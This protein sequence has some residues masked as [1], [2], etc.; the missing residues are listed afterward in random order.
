MPRFDQAADAALAVVLDTSDDDGEPA[1]AGTAFADV[2]SLLVTCH[3]VVDGRDH[4][5]L[6]N[7]SGDQVAVDRAALTMLPDYDLA[8]IRTTGLPVVP[9]PL[10]ADTGGAA[11]RFW[12]KGF[13]RT[14]SSMPGSFPVEGTLAGTAD[15]RYAS[16]LADYAIDGA[17]VLR[18]DTLGGGLSGAPVFDAD[19]G[20]VIGVLSTRLTEDGQA[21]GFA[22]PWPVAASAREIADVLAAN[23]RTVPAYGRHLNA[24]GARELCHAQVERAGRE[25]ADRRAVDVSRRVVR[26]TLDDAV[27]R[28]LAGDAM[29]LP[30][31]GPSGV[32]KSTELVARALTADR[33]ALLLRGS[34]I[35]AAHEHLGDA[36]C[37]ALRQS[38]GDRALPDRP[39]LAVAA[40]LASAGQRLLIFFDALNETPFSGAAL[41]EWITRSRAWLRETSSRMIMT[42][43]P[44]LWS[45]VHHVVTGNLVSETERIAPRSVGVEEFTEDEVRLAMRSYGLATTRVDERLLRLPL[46]LRLY[47]EL[48]QQPGIG[49]AATFHVHDLLAAYVSDRCRVVA[50]RSS[51]PGRARRIRDGLQRAAEE[52]WSAGTDHL[53]YGRFDELIGADESD[54]L[55]EEHLLAPAADES[56]YRFVYDDVQDWLACLHLDPD[57]ELSPERLALLDEPEGWRRVG[58][59]VHLLRDTERRAGHA[60]LR[61]HL[62]AIVPTGDVDKESHVPSLDVPGVRLAREVLTTV[63]DAVPYLGVLRAIAERSIAVRGHFRTDFWRLLA[64]PLPDRLDLL[65][66]LAPASHYHPWRVKDWR[67]SADADLDTWPA[68]HDYAA[69]TYQEAKQ[70]PLV[71]M[72]ALRSWFT[73]T[74]DLY[75]DDY[76]EAKVLDV[77]LGIVYRFLPEHEEAV[78]QELAATWPHGKWIF[79]ALIYEDPDRMARLVLRHEHDT[80][81]AMLMYTLT[82]WPLLTRRSKTYRAELFG[83]IE[84]LHERGDEYHR[85][86]ALEVMLMDGAEPRFLRLAIDAFEA[87]DPSV[88]AWNLAQ[89]AGI[90]PALVVDALCR[91]LPGATAPDEIMHALADV[92]DGHPVSDDVDRA[93]TGHL[94]AGTI[95]FTLHLGDYVSV[96]LRTLP[97]AGAALLDLVRGTLRR[98]DGPARRAMYHALTRPETLVDDAAARDLL[99]D[100]LV[101]ATVSD[102]DTDTV[103][104]GV[105]QC[106]MHRDDVPGLEARIWQLLESLPPADADKVGISCAFSAKSFAPALVA[107]L[108]RRRDRLSARG[109]EL[110][111]LTDGGMSPQDAVEANIIGA[112]SG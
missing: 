86:Q 89:G 40:A 103:W 25:L 108:S 20:A 5:A 11:I 56:G 62:E 92:A 60:A 27:R 78:W 41:E 70:S 71:A 38:A 2:V 107:W 58:P 13:H 14:G 65:R 73:D 51:R 53:P 111:E 94:D 43:R 52:M 112:L 3:H 106:V 8:L 84:R 77:A 105:K 35:P 18:R 24:A 36:V 81:D 67:F 99:L 16:D 6:R 64:L 109:R 59:L 66:I 39:D 50:A 37:A 17:L 30:L 80:S 76:P 72:G 47:A 82:M 44:E 85:K 7:T 1:V 42:T 61:R 87:G 19:A 21:G 45:Y 68:D 23:N 29:L 74:R 97:R 10:A 88:T 4:L 28:F 90:D 69:L 22:V 96:R 49:T 79:N 32:G 48:S 31:V 57:V 54:A 104:T 34:A 101:S 83:V 9:L 98:G 26:A 100:E 12:S 55:L 91:A 15:V 95:P 46:M 75:L 93:V 110:L 33:P 63:D 102:V